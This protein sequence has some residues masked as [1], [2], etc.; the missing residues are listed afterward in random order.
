MTE[1]SYRELEELVLPLLAHRDACEE[2]SEA[3]NAAVEAIGK[4]LDKYP[5]A[6]LIAEEYNSQPSQ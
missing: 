3:Y 2:G 5:D 1:I 6:Q 4:M